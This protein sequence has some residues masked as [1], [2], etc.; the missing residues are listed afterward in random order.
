MKNSIVKKV[1]DER[2]FVDIIVNNTKV[3]CFT[4]GKFAE[5]LKFEVEERI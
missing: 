1:V 5:K 4:S 3:N 2:L